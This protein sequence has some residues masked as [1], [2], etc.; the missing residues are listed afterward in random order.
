MSLLLSEAIGSWF[1]SNRHA[2]LE[3]HEEL[4]SKT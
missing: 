2:A 3:A 4:D 1:G